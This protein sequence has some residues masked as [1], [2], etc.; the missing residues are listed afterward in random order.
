[1]TVKGGKLKRTFGKGDSFKSVIEDVINIEDLRN[2]HGLLAA[3]SWEQA[4][5][6]INEKKRNFIVA[7][8]K[9]KEN[10][11]PTVEP[12]IKLSTIHGAKG[13]E[14]QNTV[15]MLDIDYN[16]Y[17]AYQKDPSPEH[18]LFFVGITRTVEN[19]YLVNPMGEYG[20]QI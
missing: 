7:M 4:L 11:S 18:R 19:L 15:L 10:I 9:N 20:Y 1:M 3:G 8:E 14:R 13:D 5:D 12:R 2:E 16:S 17:N 6:K